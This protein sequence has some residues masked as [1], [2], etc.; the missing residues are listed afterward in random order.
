[1]PKLAEKKESDMDR[2]ILLAALATVFMFVSPATKQSNEMQIGKAGDDFASAWN[3]HDAKAMAELYAPEGDL[4]NPRGRTAKGR[5]EIEALYRD[6]HANM[7]RSSV[8]KITGAPSIRFVEADIAFVDSEVEV[9]GALN[10]DGSAAPTQKAH[11]ARLMR[12]SGGKWW[13][14]ASR[15]FTAPPSQ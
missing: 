11:V 9:S 3:R 13:I 14:V 4:L 15:A 7:M 5:A 8:Y 12:K 2:R 6:D 10:P 1:L